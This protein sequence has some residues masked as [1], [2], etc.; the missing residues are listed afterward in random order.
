MRLTTE[1]P[2]K[3]THSGETWWQPLPDHS[4]RVA[5]DCKTPARAS[6]KTR[7]FLL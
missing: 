4:Q 1:T 7:A 5:S 6:P 3:Q 2:Q